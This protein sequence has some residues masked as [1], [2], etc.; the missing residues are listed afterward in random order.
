MVDLHAYMRAMAEKM[1]AEM[2]QGNIIV[3][4]S[5]GS[6]YIQVIDLPA[7]LSAMILNYTLHTDMHYEQSRSDEE[8]YV[9]RFEES[10]VPHSYTTQ[11]DHELEK[12]PRTHHESAYLACSYFDL[13]YILTKDTR[14]KCITIQ[15]RREWLGKY[16]RM[17]VYDNIVHEYISLKTASL[18]METLD[19]EYKRIMGE[20][21]DMDSS[22]PTYVTRVQN[23][24]M[25]LIERF[26]NNLYEK[27]F[28]ITYQVKASTYDIDQVRKVERII[29]AD[30]TAPCPTIHELSKV[31]SM[32]P[33]KLKQLFRDVYGK[34]IY[35]Y[36]QFNRMQ[37][38]KAM[39][40]SNK[41]SVKEV[42][43]SLG[44]SNLSNFSAAFRKEFH[45]LPSELAGR[46]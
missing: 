37:K 9:L 24:I 28:Q 43:L 29:T 13:G 17:E 8:L 22:H 14:L 10:Y 20:I 26:F 11:I 16:L 36:Y 30:F 38:A 41:F 46:G 44:F 31:V 12:D 15:M 27:R 23:R 1:G 39:L 18:H 40:L 34:P 7:G 33:S 25:G 45:I 21:I 32:S 2:H 35:Q 19:A 6:G 4:A 5:V 42:G 3:P